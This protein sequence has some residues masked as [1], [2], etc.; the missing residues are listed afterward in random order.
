MVWWVHP[1]DCKYNPSAWYCRIHGLPQPDFLLYEATPASEWHNWCRCA[2]LHSAWSIPD[3]HK[4][5]LLHG[6]CCLCRRDYIRFGL[7]AP[8]FCPSTVLVG[9]DD[10]CIQKQFFQFRL[11]AEHPEDIIQNPVFNPF[12][13]SAVY[14]FP[15]AITLWEITP[16]AP[17]WTIQIIVFII[18]RLSLEGRLGL[19]VFSGESRIAICSH[20]WSVN[21]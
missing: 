14:G 3:I 12:A 1:S 6:F 20:C 17:L 10:G 19:F 13:K 11:Q 15:G 7:E 9:L 8:F 21:S 18:K 5:L 4:Y 2:T 16:R